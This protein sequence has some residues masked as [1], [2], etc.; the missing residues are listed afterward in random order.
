[1]YIRLPLSAISQIGAA[2]CVVITLLPS[3]P[4]CFAGLHG[5]LQGLCHGER[6]VSGG[7]QLHL[8]LLGCSVVKLLPYTS[9][10]LSWARR[11]SCTCAATLLAGV[12]P[13]VLSADAFNY[14]TTTCLHVAVLSAAHKLSMLM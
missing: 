4:I 7:I 6:K 14:C 9:I 5:L 11:L 13:D 1:M 3:P 2:I 10:Y 12:T 8:T